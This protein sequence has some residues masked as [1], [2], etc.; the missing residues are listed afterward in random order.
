MK[1]RCTTGRIG[2][3]GAIYA[4]G[5]VFDVDDDVVAKSLIDGGDAEEV[6][7]VSAPIE[8][9]P[10]AKRDDGDDKSKKSARG[11]GKRR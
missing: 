7:D 10:V 2:I 1:L 8:P 5:D 3:G 4:T 9:E 11:T 6:A